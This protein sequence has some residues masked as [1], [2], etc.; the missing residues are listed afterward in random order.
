MEDL[1]RWKLWTSYPPTLRECEAL[2]CK[3]RARI[4]DEGVF[5]YAHWRT[6]DLCATCG[7][8]ALS[9]VR[10]E[11]MCR[12]CILGPDEPQVYSPPRT[13]PTYVETKLG[14]RPHRDRGQ[15]P[16]PGPYKRKE[17]K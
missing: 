16:K 7:K 6:L 2:A 9:K 11:P 14:Y 5:C 3:A 15:C 13:S 8:P 10:G 1:A 17:E 4:T 12:E